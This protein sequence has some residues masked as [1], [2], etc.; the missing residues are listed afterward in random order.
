MSNYHFLFLFQVSEY[1]FALK[2]LKF[3]LDPNHILQDKS[4]YTNIS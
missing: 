4:L 2:K 3:V 1:E